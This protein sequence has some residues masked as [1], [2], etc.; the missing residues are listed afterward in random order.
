MCTPMALAAAASAAR[1]LLPACP[2]HASLSPRALDKPVLSLLNQCLKQEGFRPLVL[3][4]IWVPVGGNQMV[5]EGPR[6]RK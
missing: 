6:R 3:A 1:G 5:A 4:D 2:F